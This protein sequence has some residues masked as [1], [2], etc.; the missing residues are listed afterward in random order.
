M[1][2]LASLHAGVATR[3]AP[4][5]PPQCVLTP[6]TSFDGHDIN[7]A[8]AT[9]KD[10][11]CC[12][13]CSAWPGCTAWTL[14]QGECYMKNST[15]GRKACATCSSGQPTPCDSFG[16]SAACPRPRCEWGGSSEG[17]DSS[18]GGRRGC[19][20]A[21]PPPPWV[22]PAELPTKWEMSGITF[23]GGRYCPNVTMG[24]AASLRSL[25]HLASTGANWVAIVVTQY[26]WSINSTQIFPLYNG[27]AVTDETS[28]Y[29]EFVTI[30][31]ADVT[32]TIRHARSLGLRVMLKPH[33][34]LLRDEKPA[35]RFWRGDIGGCPATDWG[36]KSPHDVTPFTPAQWTAWF[37]S[38]AKFL[39]PYAKLAHA[40]G[41]EMLAVN[42]ELY[43][44]N[45]Q[46]QMWRKVVAAVR[47]VYPTGKLT[48][49]AIAGHEKE[50]KW[51]D[52]VDVIGFDAYYHVDGSTLRAK[53]DAWKPFI[54][55]A[56]DLH[57]Q[58]NKPIAYTEIGYCSGHCSRS[59]RP[60]AANYATHAQH[61][62]AVFEAFRNYDWFLGSFWWNW[63]TDDGHFEARSDDCLTPQWK[64]AE[65][66]LRKYYRAT[67]AQP[68]QPSAPALC[69]GANKC[70]C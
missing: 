45:K 14:Y 19:T 8:A 47:Q 54:E 60:S 65:K 23:T 48:V 34:D 21:P 22:P 63:N 55:L 3:K 53:V 42:T 5:L 4:P 10:G 26:Q 49:A 30:P 12:D 66:V 1:L 35:G 13:L 52:A 68:P 25:S 37:D 29:Y 59:H 56:A 69:M 32:A 61:Y 17:A 64:P 15:A 38:Y 41:V 40:E 36:P 20:A 18:G 16:S 43:C 62:E 27:S 2:L 58:Y 24:G 39:L 57:S 7:K 11:T 50:M 70:T 67:I 28:S 46:T 9:N 6:A 51:W 44:P 33:V 31:E